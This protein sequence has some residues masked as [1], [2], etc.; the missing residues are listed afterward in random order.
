MSYIRKICPTCGSEFV[1]L[2]NIEKKANYCTLECLLKSQ[3][4]LNRSIVPHFG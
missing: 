1:V 2:E 4:E 3:E